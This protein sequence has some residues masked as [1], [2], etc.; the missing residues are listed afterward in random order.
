[1][2]RF[3]LRTNSARNP[4]KHEPEQFSSVAARTF[5]FH[6]RILSGLRLRPRRLRAVTKRQMESITCDGKQ[7]KVREIE[8]I[9]GYNGPTSDYTDKLFRARGGRYYLEEERRAPVPHNATYT[10][11]RDREW[12]DRV[13]Q[14]KLETREI[15]EKEAMLW[16]AD[17]FVSDERLR[18]RIMALID[19]FA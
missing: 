6:R 12:F 18:T 8:Q 10:M 16:Y 13:T 11:P 3:D 17:S 1:M 5:V 7:L 19:R 9:G 14:Q 15:T 4:R 2:L